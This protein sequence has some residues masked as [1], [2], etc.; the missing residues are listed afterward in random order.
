[1]NRK[2]KENLIRGGAVCPYALDEAT[3]LEANRLG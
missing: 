2:V 1:M 3:S